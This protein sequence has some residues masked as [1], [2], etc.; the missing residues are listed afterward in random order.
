ML[1]AIEGQFGGEFD[2]DKDAEAMG[3]NGLL[4]KPVSAANL[5][6]NVRETPWRLDGAVNSTEALLVVGLSC[7]A[8]F[9]SHMKGSQRLL[10]VPIEAEQGIKTRDPEHPA[11]IFVDSGEDELSACRLGL[12]LK[13]DEGSEGLARQEPHAAHVEDQPRHS[14]AVDQ[15]VQIGGDILDGGGVEDRPDIELYDGSHWLLPDGKEVTVMHCN[16]LHGGS[17]SAF[18]G[19]T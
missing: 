4:R 18:G 5:L 11:D 7:G 17:P 3:L 12:A 2:P 15:T 1:T 16:L 10:R 19:D 14:V 6:K 13:V 9:S 8:G